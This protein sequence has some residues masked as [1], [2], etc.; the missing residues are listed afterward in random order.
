MTFS[1]PR[2]N[3]LVS[4]ATADIS[5]H[6]CIDVGVGRTRCLRQQGGCRHDLPRLAVATLNHIQIK[7]RLLEC[8]ALRRAAHRLDGR[9]R[10]PSNG[11]NRHNTGTNGNTVRVHR[12]RTAQCEAT[13]KLRARK[14][15]HVAEDSK[16]RCIA[17]DIDGMYRPIDFD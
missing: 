5:S 7:P 13:A 6:R 15:Q 16:E 11:G 4:A 10:A 12:A 17:L 14:T 2:S 1:G 8:P 3:A 9:D